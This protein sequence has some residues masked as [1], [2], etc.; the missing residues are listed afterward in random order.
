MVRFQDITA[1]VLVLVI[2]G[3]TLG[4]GTQILEETGS[5]FST[6]TTNETITFVN[7]TCRSLT[8]WP[9]VSIV[10]LQNGS[11]ATGADDVSYIFDTNNYTLCTGND[12]GE[13]QVT[14]PQDISLSLT[15]NVTYTNLATHPYRTIHNAT[16]GTAELAGWIPTIALVIAAAVIIGVIFMA[17]APG[18]GGI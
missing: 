9:I 2:G 1:I 6:N 16:L 13:M 10:E 4:V 5:K 15:F 11:Q 17:F 3:I 7:G 18:R 12:E 14:L 8:Y